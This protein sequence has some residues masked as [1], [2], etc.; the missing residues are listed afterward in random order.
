MISQNEDRISSLARHTYTCIHIHVHES[1]YIH[2]WTVSQNEDLANEL[3]SLRDA[4]DSRTSAE[5]GLNNDMQ[6]R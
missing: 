1:K 5:E 6:G 2:T 4:A 3:I